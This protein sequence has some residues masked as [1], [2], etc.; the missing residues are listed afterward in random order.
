MVSWER[1]VATDKFQLT[2]VMLAQVHS[3]HTPVPFG[4]FWRGD[5]AHIREPA[6]LER[7]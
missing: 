1:S 2:T 4:D 5:A 3:I 6:I 7:P